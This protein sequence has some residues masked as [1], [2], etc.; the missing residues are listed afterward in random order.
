MAMRFLL[1]V[2]VL[3]SGCAAAKARPVAGPD[4]ARPHYL[5]E[6]RD[7]QANCFDHAG[8]LCKGAYQI[9]SSTG[10]SSSGLVQTPNG[11]LAT[12]GYTGE[13]LI[14]CGKAPACAETAV[15]STGGK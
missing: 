9:V 2:A 11:P 10:Q 15:A 12:N 14:T 8:K 5:V 3:A 13:L 6:C 1:L 4:P 7:T